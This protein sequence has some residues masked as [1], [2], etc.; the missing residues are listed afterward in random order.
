[1]K[2]LACAVSLCVLAVPAAA[3]A[4]AG[5]EFRVN[6][7]TTGTQYVPRVAM[8]AD[9]D[10]VIA[11][12]D[13]DD[14]DGSGLAV[15]ARRYAASGLPRGT[16]FQVNSY[17]T[18]AQTQPVMT[19]GHEGDLVVAWMSVQDGSGS[20][21]EA[22][23]YDAAGSPLGDEFHVNTYT[24]DNQSFIRVDRGKDG[25][26]VV[27]WTSLG[28]FDG[29]N[30]GIAARRY[31][32]SG[33]PVGDDFTVNSYTTGAQA[34]CDV[35]VN[36]DGSF[37]VVWGDQLRDGSGFAIAGQRFDSAGARVGSD[38]IVNT[39][40]ASNQLSPA[41]SASPLG[42]FVVV[43]NSQTGDG[44]GYGVFARRYDAAGAPIGSDF[45]ANSYTTGYQKEA[46]VAGD[47]RGNF[48]VVWTSD[49][50][51][52]SSGGIYAQRFTASGA[53]R[54]AEFRVNTYT[55]DKQHTPTI[56]SDDVGNFVISWTGH[57]Q[58]G[59]A[60]GAFAQRFGGL[61]PAALSVDG[62]P[63][64]SV[65][66]PGETVGV[67]PSWRN[68]SGT[69]QAFAAN[70]AGLT[71][72]GGAVYTVTDG[73][74][75]YGTVQDGA[76]ARCAD[77]YSVSVSDPAT[78][79]AVHWDATAVESIV[80]DTQGQQKG[81]SLH[82]GRSFT[83]VPPSSSFYRFVETLLHHGV[84]G[85]CN[86]T[87]YCPTVTTTRDQMAV[88]V[89]V[90]KE[91]SGYLPPACT[92]PVFADV[93]AANPFCRW[94]EELARRS[95]VGGCGNG[96]YCPTSAVSREQMAV[97]VLRALDPSL[98]PPACTTP[99]YG[100]VPAT[101]GFCRWIEELT[102]RGVV[103]G[104]GGGNYCPLAGVTREQMGVFIS[105]TFGLTLYGP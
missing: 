65:W 76:G 105:G 2:H 12:G 20:S 46:H 10:F 36:D 72:P 97:F 41:I 57:G 29:D 68:F 61:G 50:Q 104:C 4:P 88:F 69:A 39:F 55:L 17:T 7:H 49:Y 28:N 67:R 40:T 11:W 53:R 21:V 85:G 96:N 38:F 34:T 79:P 102:R 84:T 62:A 75:D 15:F 31:D 30:F 80:P 44:S 47:G 32:A 51:D 66:E 81:W 94:I 74:G 24:T 100:D 73:T 83:D 26:F 18:G 19:V 99:I 5:P 25:S 13:N 101:N 82:I 63:G 89:L 71:G 14:Q 103:G 93:P 16:E 37:V 33:S 78:R 90:A 59:S 87:Q 77:C 42:G 70:L 95:V 58:D 54:G 43:W 3:Q 56:A 86:A 35:A 52:G 92:T 64:N 45:V 48:V 8:Q 98:S 91:G 60:T 9:G 22:R 27:V 6:G 1:M 23:R